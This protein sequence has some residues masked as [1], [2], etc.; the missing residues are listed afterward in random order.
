MPPLQVRGLK[1]AAVLL[2]TVLALPVRAQERSWRIA[3][4]SADIDVHQ[5]GSADV[6][7]RIALVFIGPFHGIHRYIPVDY[8]G[9]DGTNYSIFL[10]MKSVTD[11]TGAPLKYSTKTER[12]FRVLTIY[13]PGATDT[14]KRIDILYSVRNAVKFFD[15]HDEFYWN[16]TGNG[17]SVPI[18]AASAY[19]RFPQDATG[20]LRA[21]SF[22]G[23]YHSSDKAITDIQGA[24]VVAET[25]NP[26]SAHGGLTVDVFIPKGVLASPS[27]F[28]KV[29]WFLRSNPIV[30]LPL[31]A[32]VVMF[33]LWWAKGRDPK[34]GLSVAPMYEPPKGMT[35]AE[36][37]T[38]IDDSTDPRD[39]TSTL[40]DMAVRGY[41]KIREEQVV[42]ALV[43]KKK[44]YIFVQ[45]KGP[46]EWNDLAPFEKV[47]MQNLFAGGGTETHLADLRNRFYVA[48]P[49][50][51]AYVMSALKDKGMYTLDP[52]SAHSY[53][54]LGAVLIAIPFV[55]AGYFFHVDF[56]ESGWLLGVSIAITAL[57]IFLFA[58][59]MTA[60]SLQGV[61]TRV[62]ILGFQEF[63]NRVDADRLKRMPPDTFEKFLPYAMALG[64]EHHWAKAFQGIVQNP[65]TWY[66]GGYGPGFNTWIFMHDLGMMTTDTTSAFVSTPRAAAG[67]S[68]FSSGGG[69]GGGF[70]GGG[71]GGGGGDAF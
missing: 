16:V 1:I 48:I 65:P 64:V 28:T 57:I 18:D 66:E 14:T 32:F 50:I 61:R 40:V 13:I 22:A 35:P 63:M 8:A 19:V 58:R 20:K 4:F 59:V 30:F 15:D 6:K 67:A 25:S 52:D 34:S 47:M 5:D 60:K 44:D 70:S 12:G 38:L 46:A 26:L 42:H 49:T 11:D 7:E 27:G 51:K 3:D 54:I 53:W 31:V 45:L 41:L 69:F 62:A 2:L 17:W 23:A 39:I 55:L 56:S 10:H 33:W 21:Q 24:N 29:V 71:F 37:G 36:V 9:P 43:F 68:G